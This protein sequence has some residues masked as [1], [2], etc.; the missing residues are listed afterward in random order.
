MAIEALNKALHK[1]S[2]QKNDD[3]YTQLSKTGIKA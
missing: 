2:K 1:A 3:F